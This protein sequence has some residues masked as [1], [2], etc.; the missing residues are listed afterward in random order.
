MTTKLLLAFAAGFAV[1]GLLA[2]WIM[3]TRAHRAEMALLRAE[4]RDGRHG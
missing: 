1:H 2:F 4:E 3:G